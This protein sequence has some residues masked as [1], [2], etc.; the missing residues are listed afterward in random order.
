M[1][2]TL[3]PVPPLVKFLLEV[4]LAQ[5]NPRGSLY[6]IVI[7]ADKSAMAV[8]LW[9]VPLLA[10]FM[11]VMALAQNN[12]RGSLYSIVIH[13]PRSQVYHG[14]VQ[15]LRKN[16]LEYESDDESVMVDCGLGEYLPWYE[17]TLNTAV[18]L[19]INPY[20]SGPDTSSRI[21]AFRGNDVFFDVKAEQMGHPINLRC[22][23]YALRHWQSAIDWLNAHPTFYPAILK[24]EV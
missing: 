6:S 11:R 8:T 18:C 9:P 10:T 16:V 19:R 14:C 17:K 22:S 12:P 2:A 1:A 20:R 15:Q 7:H 13:Y 21:Y 3:W 24:F 5:N 4:A 23:A